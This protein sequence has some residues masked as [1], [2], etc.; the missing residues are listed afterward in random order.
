MRKILFVFLFIISPICFAQDN[1]ESSKGLNNEKKIK[2]LP[3]NAQIYIL[4]K[5]PN[6]TIVKAG[7]KKVLW[8]KTF[9][10]HYDFWVIEFDEDGHWLKNYTP[11]GVATLD[12]LPPHIRE[13]VKTNYPKQKIVRLEQKEGNL[14]IYLD[15]NKNLSFKN[16]LE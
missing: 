9:E 15:N 11:D 7:Y 6:D 10:V 8:N 14:I 16:K 4:N 1:I 13:Q 2:H 3:L 5:Y 12:S